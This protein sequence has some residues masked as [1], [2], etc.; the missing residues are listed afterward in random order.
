MSRFRF[1]HAADLHLD[2]PLLGLSQRSRQFAARIDDASRRAFDNLIDLA[3]DEECAFIVIAGDLF[4]GKWRDYRTGLFFADRMRRL[5][6]ANIRASVILGN[7]DAENRF[8]SR[9]ELSENVHVFSSKKPETICIDELGVAIHGQ[10]FPQRDVLDN[11][12]LAYPKGDDRYF[13]IGVLHTACDGRPGHAS[14][15]PCTM[16][17]LANHGYDYWALGHVHR[18]EILNDSP[19]IVYPGNLQGRQVRE[20]GPKGGVLVTVDEG[21]VTE[22]EHRA[23]DVV[24][25]LIADT[26]ISEAVNLEA[27][28]GLIRE[29]LAICSDAAGGR[30]IAARVRLVGETTLHGNL[31]KKHSEMYEEV[32]MLAADISP[33]FWIERLEIDTTEPGLTTP[34]D[35]TIA[36]R[37]KSIIHSLAGD[38]SYGESLEAKL[39]EIRSKMPA[40]ARPEDL[41]DSLRQSAPRRALELAVTVIEAREVSTR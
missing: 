8:A 9:L 35:P 20:S 40:A 11:L 41:F 26:N 34:T 30:S 15:A 13:D 16:Q 24:R 5:K 17:Q 28:Q 25:W 10:S 21:K 18:H 19:Y 36:G 38:P 39:T 22:I 7:H 6:S 14:Y 29:S 12:A 3:I 31:L 1:L 32:Q 37:I 4:D 23:L 2:S 27:V 33:D